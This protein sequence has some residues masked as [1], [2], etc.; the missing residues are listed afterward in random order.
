[1]NKKQNFSLKSSTRTSDRSISYRNEHK[2]VELELK[3]WLFWT[4]IQEKG[5][6]ERKMIEWLGKCIKLVNYFGGLISY[7]CQWTITFGFLIFVVLIGGEGIKKRREIMGLRKKCESC[8][9]LM[10]YCHHSTNDHKTM[11][12]N[13]LTYQ[14]GY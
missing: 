5:N 3:W 14:L 10:L 1:M 13:L 4:L 6:E 12:P 7:I 11:L 2:I 8:K 9:H